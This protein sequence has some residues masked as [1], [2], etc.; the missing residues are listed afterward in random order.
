MPATALPSLATPSHNTSPTA[1]HLSAP[2]SKHL[3][4]SPYIPASRYISPRS[5]INLPPATP[6]NGAFEYF[7]AKDGPGEAADEEEVTDVVEGV[8]ENGDGIAVDRRK[9]LAEDDETGGDDVVTLVWRG[10]RDGACTETGRPP[11]VRALAIEGPGVKVS[12]A[13]VGVAVLRR[14]GS[15]RMGV[16]DFEVEYIESTD[17]PATW[18]VSDGNNV[19]DN[20]LSPDGV[21][22]AAAYS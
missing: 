14:L 15:S 7:C 16:G 8:R 21:S 17:E 1:R 4:A 10:G 6:D 22:N 11:G 3:I 5:F 9:G 13:P 18:E 12:R 2:S 20:V 19:D